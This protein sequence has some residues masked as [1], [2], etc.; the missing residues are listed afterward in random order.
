M[1]Y[2]C[3]RDKNRRNHNQHVQLLFFKINLHF[4]TRNKISTY[5]KL[6]LLLLNSIYLVFFPL[7][8][9]RRLIQTEVYYMFFLLSLKRNSSQ[10]FKNKLQKTFSLDFFS[11]VQLASINV[12]VLCGNWKTLFF[13]KVY[14]CF[15]LFFKCHAVA[16]FEEGII[17]EILF[18]NTLSPQ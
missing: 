2:F 18:F 4:V 12:F 9:Q 17:K 5:R 6:N 11:L 15:E 7:E 14:L 8:M 3:V 13:I 1:N 16:F 10:T